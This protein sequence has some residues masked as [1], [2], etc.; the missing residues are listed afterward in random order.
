VGIHIDIDPRVESEL[1]EGA[2]W[3]EET[4]ELLTIDMIAGSVDRT[5]FGAERPESRRRIVGDYVGAV[6]LADAPGFVAVTRA[7][8]ELVAPE[9]STPLGTVLTDTALRLNDAAEG[10]AGRVWVGSTHVEVRPGLGGLHVWSAEHGAAVAAEGLTLPNGIGWSPADDIIYVADSARSVV[11]HA[12]FDR[13]SGRIGPLGELFTVDGGEPDGLCVAADGT[14]W[15]AIWDGGRVEHRSPDG[16]LIESVP[17]PVSRPT[18]CALLP[19]IG[20]AITTARL[21]LT[22]EALAAEP[23]AGHLLIARGDGAGLSIARVRTG[24]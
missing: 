1:G 19:G 14:L 23:A 16:R 21:G 10:I 13:D 15:V 22:P 24:R 9:E 18:S 4:G 8:L 3:D 6:L 17:V 12:A 2:I 7:G 20:L 5:S 11:L